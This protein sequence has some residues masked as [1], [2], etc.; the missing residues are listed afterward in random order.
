MTEQAP[1]ATDRIDHGSGAGAS[2]L[3]REAREARGGTIEQVAAALK[4]RPRQV[5]AIEEGRYETLGSATYARGFV[6]S[7]ARLLG[8]DCDA[9]LAALEREAP[10]AAPVLD[11]SSGEGVALPGSG[12][13]R[14]W[15]MPL[16]ALSLPVVVG[17]GL[18][19]YYDWFRPQIQHTRTVHTLTAPV[20][21]PVVPAPAVPV[22]PEAPPAAAVPPGV[23]AETVA[24]PVASVVAPAD[25]TLRQMVLSFS[26]DSW[27]EVKDGDGRVIVSQLNRAGSELKL[28]GKAPLQLV[29]GNAAN[30]RLQ[31]DDQPVDLVPHTRVSVARVTID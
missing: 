15:L 2:A 17:V 11:V 13:R 31:V 27:V 5:E 10:V 21:A 30:V 29:I 28:Q 7:Y 24:P 4:L 23:A 12:R 8:L 3:L 19:A 26:G 25:V 16:L 9:V 18:A 14:P 22:A 20:A 1:V 6:R